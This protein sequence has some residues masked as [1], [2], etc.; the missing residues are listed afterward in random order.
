MGEGGCFF[1]F[2]PCRFVFILAMMTVID[3]WNS[4]RIVA[5]DDQIRSD[6][7]SSPENK[8]GGKSAELRRAAVTVVR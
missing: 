1:D 6:E 7:S 5:P 4:L 8:D 2:F 3:S